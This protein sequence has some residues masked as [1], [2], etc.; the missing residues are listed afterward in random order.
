MSEKEHGSFVKR[1]T[2]VSPVDGKSIF[3]ILALE[4]LE[5][6]AASSV[7]GKDYAHITV[8]PPGGEPFT[9]STDNKTFRSIKAA[10]R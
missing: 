6:D 5:W 3:G 1:I 2:G 4:V 8:R 7:D 10:L 9:I